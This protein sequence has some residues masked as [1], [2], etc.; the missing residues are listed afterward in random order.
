MSNLIPKEK[1]EAACEN[2]KNVVIETPF[3]KQENLSQHYNANI[4]LKRE[5]K[6]VVRSFK[7]RGAYHKMSLMQLDHPEKGVICASA[8]NHAQGVAMACTKLNIKGQIYMPS[9][10]PAQKIAKVNFFGGANVE[11]ILHGDTFDEAYA[12]AKQKSDL[13]GIPL[14]HPFDDVDVIA[15]QGTIAVEMLS[16]ADCTF[17]YLFVAVGGG[18]L[19]AGVGSYWK[20]VSPE[21]KIIAVEAE[22]APSFATSL[23]KNGVTK[24]DQIN[25]FADGIAVKQMGAITYPICAEVISDNVLVPEGMICSKILQLYNDEAIV[26]EPAGA[27]G[28]AALDFYKKELEGK[29]VAVILCGGNNDVTRTEDI[30]ER[31]LLYEGLKHYF[32]INFPQRAGALKEFLHVLGPDDDISFFQYTKKTNKTAGP[33]TVGI[34]LKRKGDFNALVDKM[35]AA[36]IKFQHI[37]NNPMLFEILI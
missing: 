25:S 4:Y 21:T 27:V 26:A 11:I 19:L 12:V 8:G 10:T 23:E 37:N 31:A 3:L 32:I 1:I 6:Q 16:Q 28:I 13:E 5:D 7:I 9:T 22:G 18:G 33:A 34:E 30:R 35:K 20:Q 24:L 15:G 36:K 17:D 2:L 29:N 14:I